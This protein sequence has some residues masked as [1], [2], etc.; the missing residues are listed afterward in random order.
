[1]NSIEKQTVKTPIWR[2]RLMATWYVLFAK[3]FF[4]LGLDHKDQ[5]GYSILYH[6]EKSLEVL[7]KHLNQATA[8]LNHICKGIYDK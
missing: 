1:M 5:K 2:V 6:N 8:R 7:R 3:D 4:I